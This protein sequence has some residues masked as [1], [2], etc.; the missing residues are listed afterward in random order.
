MENNF[1][2]FNKKMTKFT[3]YSLLGVV[4]FGVL[5]LIIKDFALIESITAGFIGLSAGLLVIVLVFSVY[6]YFRMTVKYKGSLHNLHTKT[7][8]F[9]LKNKEK[10]VYHVSLKL[11]AELDI[12]CEFNYDALDHLYFIHKDIPYSILIKEYNGDILGNESD[13]QWKIGYKRRK[14]KSY[15]N[16]ITVNNPILQN[17]RIIN[18]SYSEN[19]VT[20]NNLILVTDKTDKSP[21]LRKVVHLDELLKKLNK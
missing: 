3:I 21:L 20:V 4:F 19:V 14:D 5:S 7:N 6:Y 16:R 10:V 15:F 2:L 1:Y 13:L 8:Y 12:D 17:Q 18:R 11:K 9:D